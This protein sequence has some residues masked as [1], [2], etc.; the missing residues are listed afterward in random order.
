MWVRRNLAMAV[1]CATFVLGCTSSPDDDAE[2]AGPGHGTEFSPE[3][4]EAEPPAQAQTALPGEDVVVLSAATAGERAART[5]EMVFDH[6]PV[7]VLAAADDLPAQAAAAPVAVGL[8]VPLLLA[9]G[10]PSADARHSEDEIQRLDPQAVLAFGASASRWAEDLGGVEVSRAPDDP[11]DLSELTGVDLGEPV[12]VDGED[13]VTAVAGLDPGNPQSGGEP[14]AASSFPRVAPGEPLENLT[15]LTDP[16]E[17]NL[18]AAATARASGARV[19]VTDEADPRADP[20]LIAALAR[21]DTDG[22][23]EADTVRALALGDSFGSP[24][25][26]RKRLAV[27]ATGRELPGGGQVLFPHRRFIALYGTPRSSAMGALGE[28]PLEEAIERAQKNAAEYDGLVDEPIVPAFEIITTIA[29]TEPGP[30][31]DY[32]SR[33]PVQELRPWVDAAAEAGVYVVLDLQ[34]GHTDFLSQ[35]RE[36][37]ELLLEPHVGLAL[38]P[39]WRLEAGQRHLNQIGSVDAAEINEVSEW[40]AALTEEHQLPQKLLILHQF[41][42]AMIADR[43]DVET[44]YDE[45]AILI[46]ADGFGTPQLKFETWNRLHADAPD[47]IWWGWKN[48]IDEDQPTFTPEETMA[49][50][51]APWFVSYQ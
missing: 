31:G 2:P 10:E 29:H 19:L 46:H 21:E 4:P 8:G 30:D 22:N 25:T 47:G 51:P 14:V 24:E 11:R 9:P 41:T 39:E 36:Y 33:T 32:S 50:E 43:E 40:L 7:V 20:D 26:L 44:G 42:L 23:D 3:E 5:S 45:L 35:A 27:A 15:V 1:A 18:A 34:P 49:I 37:E 17:G 12:E 16:D 48:F 6:A 13:V 28:Q 38:D